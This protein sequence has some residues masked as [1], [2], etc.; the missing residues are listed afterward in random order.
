MIF[1]LAMLVDPGWFDFYDN[2]LVT[3]WIVDD[4]KTIPIVS[5]WDTIV[6]GAISISERVHPPKN[7][8]SNEQKPLSF[9]VYRG[10]YYTVTVNDVKWGL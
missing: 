7:N 4:W 10:L 1:Q 9:R 6:S 5:F 8:M 3:Y 2:F